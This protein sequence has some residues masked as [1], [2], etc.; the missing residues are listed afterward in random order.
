MAGESFEMSTVLLNRGWR[1]I[2]HEGRWIPRLS[3]V[4][5]NVAGTIGTSL[6]VQA[7][8]VVSGVAAARMLGVLDRGH[9][10]MFILLSSVLPVICSLGLPL[11]LTYWIARA[12]ELAW[13]LLIRVRLAFAL[14]VGVVLVAH[15]VV[16]YLLFLHSPANVQVS[17]AIS[18]ISSPAVL[19]WIFGMAVL[20]GNQQFRAL[21]V[22]RVISPP[23]TAVLM[24]SYLLIGLHSLV[25]ATLTWTAL[26]WLTALITSIAVF[27]GMPKR[28]SQRHEDRLP[29]FRSLLGFSLKA[30][31]GSVTPLEGFQLDQAI[32]GIFLS[33]A[34][35]GIYVVAVAFTNL[36]RFVAQ[37]IGL[38]GYPHVAAARDGHDS[39]RQIMKFMVTTLALCGG[40]VA[41][42]ELGLPFLVPALFGSAFHAAIGVAQILLI[43]ALLFALRRVLSECARGANRPGLGSLA[44]AISLVTL[45]PA[46]ALLYHSG[47]RGVAVALVVAAFAGLASMIVGLAW[48]LVPRRRTSGALAAPG[49]TALEAS[50][51]LRIDGLAEEATEWTRQ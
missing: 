36:P 22:S 2:R 35:L 5:R 9:L 43:S 29:P 27:R 19:L 16:L 8:L 26:I 47:A 12:P 18:W 24:A 6:A 23:I 30:L 45:F 3:D 37:A 10:A 32:V 34:A 14:L 15:A 41:V 11:A 33:Q 17:A 4:H 49:H 50:G 40:T 39:A 1:H 44:E 38:V 20:Q 21:N 51:E 31:L 25:L 13:S 46:V 28:D 48:P 7:A 42:I